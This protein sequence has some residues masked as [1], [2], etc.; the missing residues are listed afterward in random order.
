MFDKIIG[1]AAKVAGAALEKINESIADLNEAIPILKGLGLSVQN[2]HLNMGVPPE[3]GARLIGSIEAINADAFQKLIE[4]H[5]GKKVLV[6]ILE[7]L[8]TASMLKD[9]L[10]GLGFK[11]VEVDV[12]LGLSPKVSVQFLA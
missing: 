11:G 5:P 8:R 9:Q 12:T 7:A 3:I 10:E 1:E 2:F 6:A 4:G